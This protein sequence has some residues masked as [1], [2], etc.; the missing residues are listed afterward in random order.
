MNIQQES[1]IKSICKELH[2]NDPYMIADAMGMT[3]KI[4]NTP[5]NVL[6]I[7]TPIGNKSFAVI[8]D[9]VDEELQRYTVALCLYY[10]VC[11]KPRLLMKSGP[12]DGDLSAPHFAYDLL[13]CGVSPLPGETSTEYDTRIGIPSSIAHLGKVRLH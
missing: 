1:D 11:N 6:A 3:I 10:H 5:Y 7:Y 4:E 13:S 12:S 2:T 9:E 8:S